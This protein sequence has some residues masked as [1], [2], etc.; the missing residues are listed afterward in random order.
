MTSANL[1]LA[2]VSLLALMGAVCLAA[3]TAPV[4]DKTLV[5]WVAP[6]SLTQRGGSALTIDDMAT[7]FD[8]IIFGELSPGKW[9]AGSDFY[10]RTQKEQGGCPAETAGKETFVQVAIVYRGKQVT[11]YRNGA[12]YAEYTMASPPRAFGPESVVM[13]GRRHVDAGDNACFAGLIDDARIYNVA[14]DAKMIASLRPNRPSEPKAWAW[15]TFEDGLA[16]DR[17]GRFTATSLIAGARVA[18]GKLVLDGKGATMIASRGRQLVD[19]LRERSAGRGA[20]AGERIDVARQHRLRVLADR[21]RPAYHFV[22]L[23]GFCMPFDPNGAIFWNGRYHLFYIYQDRGRHYW[24]HASSRDL[25]HWRHHPPALFPAPGDPDKGIFSGNCFVNKKGEAT[26][27]YHGVGAG[28]CIAVSAETHLDRWEK[29]PANPIQPKWSWDPHGWLEG[30]TYYAISGGKPPRLFKADRLDHWKLLG[31]FMAN[32]VQGVSFNEDV[33][34][35]DFFKLGDRHM[36]LCISHR[37][38]CRYYLGEW[39]NEKFHPDFHEKMSWVDNEFFAPESLLDDRG[40]RIMWAWVFDRRSGATRSASG[41]SGTM[42]LPRVL[43]LGKDGRL[44]MRPV[45]ELEA[46]RCNGKKLTDLAVRADSE[47]KLPNVHGDCMELAIE[48]VPDAAK[49]FGVKVCCSPK[50][51]EQTL[52][53]YDAAEKKL[54]VDTRKSSLGEGPKKVEAGPFELK[55]GEPLKLR[56]FVDRSVVEVFA[57]DRQAVTRRIYPSRA[58]SVGVVLFSRGGSSKVP[59]LQAWSMMPSN[60]Y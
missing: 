35:P 47:L 48:M 13:M 40:R 27:L 41:W 38:G 23:E 6:A 25:L 50:G 31:N 19:W 3:E 30:D 24:G 55:A 34:C 57:N 21:H 45:A 56:V 36:L 12:K 4:R 29:L 16:A 10:R 54:K 5:V 1:P 8:G 18:D 2:V 28:N 43:S 37:W 11:I 42:S 52:V 32:T 17:M 7:R 15:W 60:P 51:E 33:S 53:F 49:Q 22:V 26:I 9:M 20:A 44:R 59:A 14:V 46:L 58:D 39:K